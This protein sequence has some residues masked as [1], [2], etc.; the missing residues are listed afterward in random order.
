MASE[1]GNR[2][3]FIKQAAAGALL[4]SS[5]STASASMERASGPARKPNV[6]IFLADEVRWDFIDAIGGNPTIKT[7]NIDR[8]AQ[9]G[10][11]FTHAVTNQ[12]LCSP[13]RA[14][15]LTGRY[16]TETGVWKLEV[17]L[18]QDIPT[19]ATIL[20]SHGYTANMIGKWHLAAANVAT[21]TGFGWT[22]PELRGGFL[23]VWEGANVYER[24]THPYEGTIWDADGKEIKWDNEYRVDFLTDRVVRFLER[25][26]DKPFLLYISQLEP[27]FQN[28]LNTVVGPKGLAA[29]YQNPYVPGDLLPLPGVWQQELPDYYAAIESIDASVGRVIETLEKQGMLDNT[30]FLFTSDHGCHFQTRENNYKRTPHDS[31]IRIP[32]VMAGPGIA[33]QRRVDAITGNINVT[34]TLLELCGITPLKE[35][36]GRSMVAMINTLQGEAKWNNRE[37]IQISGTNG[38]GMGRAIRTRD[39]TY[40]I[41]NPTGGND[42]PH[43]PRYSEYVMFNNVA[44]P[45]QMVNLCGRHMY[46]QQADSL[47]A[48]LLQLIEDS[49]DP[50]PIIEPAHLLHP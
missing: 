37:L 35:M 29:K 28:D 48:E 33:S 30:V 41:A 27:H 22:K 47:R 45:H 10:T 9:R 15:M 16:P 26:H 23:D 36:K 11:L 8:L 4:A 50:R 2:R 21:K 40:S 44:D 1:G 46:H 31:S 34:P 43:A 20:R 49:G 6:V 42:M 17:D 24:V 32:L 19:L 38:T 39:W 7:P 13:S 12:P 25:K 18:R 5:S 14:C 3:D